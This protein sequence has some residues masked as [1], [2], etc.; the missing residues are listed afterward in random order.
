[1]L[2]G[3]EKVQGTRSYMSPEQI[4]GKGVD[5]RSDIYGLACMMHEL[6]AGKPPFTGAN[7]KSC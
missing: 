4:R 2:S 5:E 1:M 7:T 3:A 6:V